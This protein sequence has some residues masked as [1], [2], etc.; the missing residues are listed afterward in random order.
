MFNKAKKAEQ[1]ELQ[2]LADQEA[3]ELQAEAARLHAEEVARLRRERDAAIVR[4]SDEE[5]ARLRRLVES[6]TTMYLHREQ[7]LPVDGQMNV[8][9]AAGGV[10]RLLD[11]MNRFGL[12][13]WEVVSLV[14]R[15]HGGFT[16]HKAPKADP[17]SAINTGT[18]NLGTDA[19]AVVMGGHSVGVYAFLRYAVNE[20]NFASS[21]AAIRATITELL[22]EHLRTPIV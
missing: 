17:A 9:S 22:P 18:M 5:F 4:H 12:Q 2:R 14:P 19:R 13:G 10:S 6:G 1:R 7:Y 16:S 11:E 20:R 3:R 15:T 8:L 21:E